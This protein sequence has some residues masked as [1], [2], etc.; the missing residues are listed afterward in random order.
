MYFVL[1]ACREVVHPRN[2]KQLRGWINESTLQIFKVPSKG[3]V[4]FEFS[5]ELFLMRLNFDPAAAV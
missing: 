3:N 2:W 4:K 5:I 1:N